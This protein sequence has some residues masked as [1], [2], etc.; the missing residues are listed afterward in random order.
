MD[1]DAPPGVPEWVVTYG[2]MMSLLLTFFIMLV[3]MSQ[4]KEEGR[5]STA[6]DSLREVFGPDETMASGAPGRS[7]LTTSNIPHRHSRGFRNERDT[8]RA[9]KKTPGKSGAS[10]PVDRL[11]EGKRVTLGGPALFGRFSAE[12]TDEL[13]AVLDQL[14]AVMDQS[15]KQVAVR[16]HASPEP[17]PEGGGELTDHQSLAFE[18][19]ARVAERLIERGVS[20]GRLIISSAGAAEP[21]LKTRDPARQRLNDRVDVFLVDSYAV[22]P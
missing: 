7:P 10:D 6:L 22:V 2:D 8:D 4:L 3:S 15:R 14:A 13:N 9:S 16:G 21:R 12:P 19:A 1:D 11:R 17:L 18:R 20:P 5:V